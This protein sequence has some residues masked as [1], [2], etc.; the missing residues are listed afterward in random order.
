[1]CTFTSFDGDVYHLQQDLVKECPIGPIGETE[2]FADLSELCAS[3]ISK[4][5][6]L[7]NSIASSV[8]FGFYSSERIKQPKILSRRL[9][10]HPR[11]C[12]ASEILGCCNEMF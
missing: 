12:F 10:H 3:S 2:A 11:L 6:F 5:K 4:T 1:M 8:N 9:C 7:S